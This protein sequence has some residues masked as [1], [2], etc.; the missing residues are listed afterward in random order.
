MNAAKEIHPAGTST[1][2]VRQPHG[3]NGVAPGIPGNVSV[4]GYG[5][6]IHP[7]EL[8]ARTHRTR[9]AQEVEDDLQIACRTIG[10]LAGG[11]RLNAKPI[12]RTALK[13]VCE[14]VRRLL[15][16]PHRPECGQ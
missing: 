15:S 8:A 2:S 6:E 1:G 11:A 9:T 5:T 3:G 14:G 7:A 16:E 12:D 10:A 13:N 4:L